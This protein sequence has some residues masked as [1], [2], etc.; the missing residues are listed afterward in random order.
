MVALSSLA[1]RSFPILDNGTAYD[2][3]STIDLITFN[4]PL[5][6]TMKVSLSKDFHSEFILGLC[7]N[8]LGVYYCKFP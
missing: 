7:W 3:L 5:Q 4:C 8:R 2:D 1:S 6:S